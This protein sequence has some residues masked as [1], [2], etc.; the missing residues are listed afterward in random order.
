MVDVGNGG[1]R[2]FHIPAGNDFRPMWWKCKKSREAAISTFPGVFSR[3]SKAAGRVD[4]TTNR[5][6]SRARSLAQ[7]LSVALG[8]SLNIA[9]YPPSP[10]ASRTGFMPN[11]SET[12]V[13][14]A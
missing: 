3:T 7:S 5:S 10:K 11:A 6:P 13:T 1:F 8:L 9:T 2:D 14:A 12:V 4:I